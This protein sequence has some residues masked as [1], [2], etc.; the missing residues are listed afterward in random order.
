MKLSIVIP[1]YNE[2]QTIEA[3]VD[4]VLASPYTTEVIVVDDGSVDGTRQLLRTFTDPRIRVILHERN[5]GKGA[6]L[7]SAFEAASGDYVI[8]QD[9]D[10]EYDPSDYPV[11]L[12]PLL[13]G[14][15]DVVYGSRFLGGSHRVL[16]FW[17]MVA[18]QLL[19]LISNM[20]TNLNLTDMETG[21]KAFR[22]EVV[23]NLQL[24]SRRFDVEPEIT[25]RIAQLG[26]RVYE[27]PISYHGR[28]YEDG[29]KI[30]WKDGV[31]AIVAILRFGL[32]SR[33][34]SRH[35]LHEHAAES[36]VTVS[37][38]RNARVLSH[39]RVMMRNGHVPADDLTHS[40]S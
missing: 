37:G 21:Y 4:R 14:H 28:G 15:A 32:I 23:K 16:F 27:V 17:H 31:T 30:G 26:C 24:R 11:L 1:A 12:E 38:A 6:A 33:E 13:S 5:R 20:F 18:N 2:V 10:L 39:P 34:T 22:I 3:I 36:L 35:R 19:T 25:A 29:K 8:I 7:K 9:A 40:A